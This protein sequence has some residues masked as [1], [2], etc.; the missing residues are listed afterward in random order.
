[1]GRNVFDFFR[2]SLYRDY[3][4]NLHKNFQVAPP[5]NEYL[6]YQMAQSISGDVLFKDIN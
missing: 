2:L 3:W 6:E 5:Y 4:T 1:M